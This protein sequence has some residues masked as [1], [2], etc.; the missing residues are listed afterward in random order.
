MSEM[1]FDDEQLSMFRHLSKGESVRVTMLT[2]KSPKEIEKYLKSHNVSGIRA[3]EDTSTQCSWDDTRF[4]RFN[5][6]MTLGMS[7][8]TRR[9]N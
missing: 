9:N 3:T 4:L 6:H 2:H 5:L 1:L 8:K 7:R